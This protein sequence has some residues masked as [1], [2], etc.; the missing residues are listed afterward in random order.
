VW[1]QILE[2]LRHI[3]GPTGFGNQVKCMFIGQGSKRGSRDF[4][5]FWKA[6]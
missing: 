6:V 5:I 4:G 1:V 2:D 3:I